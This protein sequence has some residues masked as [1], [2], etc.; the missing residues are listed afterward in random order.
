MDFW[1]VILNLFCE[2]H[3][4]CHIVELGVQIQGSLCKFSLY[5]YPIIKHS[6]KAYK[7]GKVITVVGK[8]NVWAIS[9]GENHTIVS[10]VSASGFAL[11]PFLI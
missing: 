9:S 10:C 11:P 4:L 1:P 3:N 8:K 5:L 6:F 2:V 7:G